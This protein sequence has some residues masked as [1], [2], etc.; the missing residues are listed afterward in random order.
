M[1]KISVILP[2]YNVEQYIAK[3]IH[4]VL[5]QSYI[6]FELIVVIDGS[7]DNSEVIAREFEKTDLRVKV[8]TKP[9]GGLSDARNY[10]LNMATGEFIYFLD[11]DDWIE[12]NLL[13]DN[14]KMLEDK[15]LDFIVFGF[16]QDN[17]DS[18]EQL[19]ENIPHIP[20]NNEWINSEPIYFTPYMLNILG[21]AWNKIYRKGYLD[22]HQ[23]KFTI[24]VSL[25]EDILFNAKVYQYADRIV[26][27]P[28][29]YVHYIQRPVVTLTKQF[30]EQ[31]FEWVKLK[32]EGLQEF[33]NAWSFDNKQE[34]LASNL[35]GGLRYCVLNLF[36]YKNQFN[37]R[38]K[39]SYIDKMLN[40][41]DVINY[42]QFYIPESRNDKIYYQL[43]KMRA[44]YAIAVMAEIRG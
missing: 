31:S 34:I 22:K 27:N 18:N 32:H 20:E 9:N 1:P 44:K 15:N 14:I 43:I 21:Y 7:K 37:F 5:N 42:L 28:K 35:I 17:V 38:Q 8:Y 33:L 3:S 10:G 30:H 6:D 12:P 13:E 19:I 29:P 2:V 24:G 26:F 41:I 16:Y 39:V 36:R 23:I 11:S 40:D 4:S 25:V